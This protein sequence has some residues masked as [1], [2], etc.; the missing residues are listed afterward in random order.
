MEAATA[1][2]VKRRVES[3]RS[4][5]AKAS[6]L[7]ASLRAARPELQGAAV[8]VEDSC[9]VPPT[10][11]ASLARHGAYPATLHQANVFVATNP[12]SPS[13]VAVQWVAVLIGAW[14]VEP[15]VFQGA[16]AA[17]AAVKYKP[18]LRTSRQLWV[19][20]A[21]IQSH[22]EVWR[23]I[24]K[25][26]RAEKSAVVLALTALPGPQGA[27]VFDCGGLLEFIKAPLKYSLGLGCN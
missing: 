16:E 10:W 19:D 4:R 8:F 13:S 14:V 6:R 12:W 7:Q 21:I 18:A 17:G 26:M 2:E 24:L 1:K 27:H 11:D 3:L 5:E 23:A 20:R 25:A 9:G 15:A 22:P